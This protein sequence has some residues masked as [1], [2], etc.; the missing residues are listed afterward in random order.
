[1]LE[2]VLTI[3]GVI[4]LLGASFIDSTFVFAFEESS[5][6][7]VISS[8]L[9]YFSVIGLLVNESY[10]LLVF[11]IANFSFYASLST[12]LFYRMLSLRKSSSLKLR[13]LTIWEI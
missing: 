10:C 6:F 7:L 2:L 4:L 8:F 13:L 12:L 11:I 3:R 9:T 1:M 5:L